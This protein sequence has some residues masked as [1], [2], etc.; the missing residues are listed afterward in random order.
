MR[1]TGQPMCLP[2]VQSRSQ[3]AKHSRSE[4]GSV[5]MPERRCGI[6]DQTLGFLN[7]SSTRLSFYTPLHAEVLQS[8]AHQ[9][10]IAI[11]NARLFKETQRRLAAQTAL[12]NA[13][14][15][16]SST[17]DLPIVLQRCAEQLCRASMPPAPISATG[18]V[19]LIRRVVVADYYSPQALGTGTR[20]RSA[21]R[22]KINT[23]DETTWFGQRANAG[24]ALADPNLPSSV[25]QHMEHFGVQSLLSIPLTA[26]SQTFGYAVLWETR[27]RREF[28][29]EEIQLCLGIAQQ[30]ATAFDNA[31]LL[32]TARQQLSLSRVLQAVGAL[33]TGRDESGRGLRTHL[34][35][36]GGGGSLRLCLDRIV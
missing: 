3:L 30:T 14:S 28:T 19:K 13:S 26:R 27:R 22:A 21:A 23:T 12:L 18:I 11:Q 24:T 36:I 4:S 10:A 32:D 7:L 15:A 25:R 5:R 33:L 20:A 17:L 31:R 16:I 6:K 29:P 1:D 34:Q 8:F 35:S 9:A 2:D